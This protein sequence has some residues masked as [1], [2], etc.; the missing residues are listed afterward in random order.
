MNFYSI[1]KTP[2]WME[3]DAV[4]TDTGDDKMTVG[5]SA[6]LQ[7]PYYLIPMSGPSVQKTCQFGRERKG[8]SGNTTF[9]GEN[10]S[11]VIYRHTCE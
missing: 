6:S 1:L 10:T 4:F 9:Y 8:K 2:T 7:R 5:M 3:M 11:R